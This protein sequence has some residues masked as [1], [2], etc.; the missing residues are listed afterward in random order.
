MPILV[1]G[2]GSQGGDLEASVVSGAESHSPNLLISSS[3]GVIYAS[4]SE[5]DFADA[6]NRAAQDLKDSINEALIFS[7]KPWS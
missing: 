6:A 1:P 7:E 5:D 4:R 2:V 3:R